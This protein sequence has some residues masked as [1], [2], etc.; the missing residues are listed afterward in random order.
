MGLEHESRSLINGSRSFL[1][2]RKPGGTFFRVGERFAL[3]TKNNDPQGA[4]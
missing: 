4:I 2:A 3:L 1:K